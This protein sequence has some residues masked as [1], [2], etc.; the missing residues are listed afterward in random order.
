MAQLGRSGFKS[1]LAVWL[2]ECILTSLSLTVPSDKWEKSVLPLIV[3]LRNAGSK[4]CAEQ[5]GG[6]NGKRFLRGD[7]VPDT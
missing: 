2:W 3:L 5:A 7:C 1:Q 4:C 6:D